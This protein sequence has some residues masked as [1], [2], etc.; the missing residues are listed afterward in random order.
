[1]YGIDYTSFVETLTTMGQHASFLITGQDDM[2]HYGHRL[3]IKVLFDDESNI[4]SFRRP[5]IS[6]SQDRDIYLLHSKVN[7]AL[8]QTR[9]NNMLCLVRPDT[10]EVVYQHP[11]IHGWLYS[12]KELKK[13]EQEACIKYHDTFCPM[14]CNDVARL[15]ISYSLDTLA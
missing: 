1:M 10:D 9:K 5:H 7:T 14:F 4:K 2:F 11:I 12:E 3:T 8:Y 13:V 6:F 15:I